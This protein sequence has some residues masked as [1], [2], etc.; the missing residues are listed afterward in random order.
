MTKIAVIGDPF[1]DV[2]HVG[3]VRGLSAE[4]PIPIVDKESILILPGGAANVLNNL[5]S[6]G[7]DAFLLDKYPH[8]NVPVKN[9]LMSTDG[10]QL[11]RWD[12][13]DW[14][15]PYDKGDLVGLLEADA[16]VVADYGKG[17][18]SE[19]VIQILRSVS[20]PVFVDTKKDPAPW[21]GSETATLFPN[22]KEFHQYEEHYKWLPR[23]ILKRGAEGLAFLEFGSVVLQRPAL[24]RHVRSVNGAGDTV[25]AAFTLAALSGCT[26]I[27]CLNFANAAAADVVEQ[28]FSQRYTSAESAAS[29]MEPSNEDGFQYPNQLEGT[30]PPGVPHIYE[31]ALLEA[32]AGD[33]TTGGASGATIE[34]GVGNQGVSESSP[35]VMWRD[36]N[37]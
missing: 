14:C 9:R 37:F 1:I 15:R 12:E 16:I 34:D 4:A 8:Q 2:Y 30:L 10:T 32:G 7:A 22:L 6:L 23:V 25:L 17:S 36:I 5:K 27:Q 29:R 28:P 3:R 35:P 33:A 11:A 18:V 19:E 21:L 26:L 31:L 13:E 20:V 24:A